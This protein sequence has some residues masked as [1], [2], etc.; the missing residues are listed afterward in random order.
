MTVSFKLSDSP[1]RS[2]TEKAISTTNSTCLNACDIAMETNAN[3]VVV[4]T[5]DG[6]TAREI[7]KHRM[8]T[9]IITICPTEKVARHLTLVWGINQTFVKKFKKSTYKIEEILSFL[10]KNKVVKKGNKVVIVCHASKKESLI[11]TTKI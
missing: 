5:E 4:Y 10:K 7:A 6:Y 11:S 9:P 2:F 8:Y 3:F 1:D